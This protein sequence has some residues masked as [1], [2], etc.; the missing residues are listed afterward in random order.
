[1][2]EASQRFLRHEKLIEIYNSYVVIV[3]D[4]NLMTQHEIIQIHI[5]YGQGVLK[6]SVFFFSTLLITVT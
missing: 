3:N 1:L 4:W 2:H 6:L 5:V